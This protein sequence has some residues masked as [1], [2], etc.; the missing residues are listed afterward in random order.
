[1]DNTTMPVAQMTTSRNMVESVPAGLNESG[2]TDKEH[3]Y[4]L[5]SDHEFYVEYGDV[6]MLEHEAK[7]NSNL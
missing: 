5:D 1:M 2:F 7:A 3:D 6:D 4:E